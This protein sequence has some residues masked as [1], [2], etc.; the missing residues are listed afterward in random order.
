MK[1]FSI[2]A[3]TLV[4]ILLAT[5]V[6]LYS[7]SITN[8]YTFEKQG[9]IILDDNKV[10]IEQNDSISKTTPVN[11]LVN[12]TVIENNTFYLADDNN[13]VTLLSDY[14]AV[15]SQG[16]I[17]FLPTYTSFIY[18][19]SNY[20]VTTEQASITS[21]EFI[22]Y[23]PGTNAIGVLSSTVQFK[24]NEYGNIAVIQQSAGESI[25][26]ATLTLSENYI[27]GS[28]NIITTNGYVDLSTMTYFYDGVNYVTLEN[29]KQNNNIENVP[30]DG[31]ITNNNGTD[32]NGTDNNGTTGNSTANNSESSD[33]SPSS[34]G[35]N[36]FIKQ[37]INSISQQLPRV[38]ATVDA[39]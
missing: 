34:N 30:A 39:K 19:G 14:Y 10:A 6:Y 22:L 24:E 2:L 4:I 35:L 20:T 28:D 16:K 33:S 26:L 29:I 23:K 37:L 18:D 11:S 17:Y 1:K 25:N 3:G 12:G 32:N 21:D 38:F 31:N 5:S 15:D 13:T 9:T 27:V 36:N 8:I 7:N